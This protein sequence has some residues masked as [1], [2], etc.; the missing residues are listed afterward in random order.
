MLIRPHSDP[1]LYVPGGPLEPTAANFPC[2]K[3]FLPCTE[4]SGDNT[5]TDVIGGSIITLTNGAGSGA[6]YVNLTGANADKPLGRS[7]SIGNLAAMWLV[8]CDPGTVMSIMFGTYLSGASGYDIGNSAI[9]F[10]DGPSAPFAPA[11]SLAT[12]ETGALCAKGGTASSV[13]FLETTSTTYTANAAAAGTPASVVD[14]SLINLSS[15]VGTSKLYGAAFFVFA[16]GFPP[17]L[18]NIITWT[19]WNWRNKTENKGLYPGL[20]GVA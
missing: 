5:L 10:D 20:K 17:D 3:L 14:V 9:S 6:G 12:G 4:A 2:C 7:V 15:I 16:N 13:V 11:G 18:R 1:S 19:H 8:S